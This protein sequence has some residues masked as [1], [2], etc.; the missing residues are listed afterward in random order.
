MN[1]RFPIFGSRKCVPDGE[2]EN[3]HKGASNTLA[4]GSCKNGEKNRETG[5]GRIEIK[6]SMWRG[7]GKVETHLPIRDTKRTRAEVSTARSL[8]VAAIVIQI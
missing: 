7:K 6:A 1:K 2:G 5:A 3:V 4:E 8:F